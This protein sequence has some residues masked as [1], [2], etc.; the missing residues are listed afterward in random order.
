MSQKFLLISRALR[1]KV[2]GNQVKN[3]PKSSQVLRAYLLQR[4]LPSWTAF[5]VCQSAIE[6]DLWGQSHFNFEVDSTNYH[7]LR[8]GAFPFVKFHCTARAKGQDLTLENWFY[9]VLKVVNF[10][11]PCFLYGIAGLIW[12]SHQEE[13]KCEGKNIFF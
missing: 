1:A 8:T 9:N 4:N 7:V 13:V 10:G 6:N 11:F 2:G 12:T 3:L 5:Y